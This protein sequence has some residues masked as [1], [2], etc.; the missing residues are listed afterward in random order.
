[1][2]ITEVTFYIKIGGITMLIK[3]IIDNENGKKWEIYKNSDNDYFYKYYEF[4]QVTGWRIIF[5]ESNYS[6]DAIEWELDTE[7]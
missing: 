6:K 7:I 5:T 3:T 1:M 2:L 4:F